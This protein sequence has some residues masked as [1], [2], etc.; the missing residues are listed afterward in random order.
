MSVEEKTKTEPEYFTPVDP[1]VEKIGIGIE[2]TG[3]NIFTKKEAE[4]LTGFIEWFVDDKSD[5]VTLDIIWTDLWVDKLAFY[6][7][8]MRYN[9]GV[10]GKDLSGKL[11]KCMEFLFDM[12]NEKRDIVNFIR[13]YESEFRKYHTNYRD[14]SS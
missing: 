7:I 14:V 9:S 4:D 1:R 6:K 8:F 10:Y 11:Q 5:R 2:P 13:D 12:Y 3:E